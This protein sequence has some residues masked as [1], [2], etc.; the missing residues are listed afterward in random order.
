MA[1]VDGQPIFGALWTCMD[2]RGIRAQALTLTKSHE[3]RIGPLQ[4]IAKS[5][6][7]YG[8]DDPLVV[9]TDDPIK[10]CISCTRRLALIFV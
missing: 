2:S 6:E 5:I 7:L 9:F 1:S 3:E 4:G 10:A 8:F